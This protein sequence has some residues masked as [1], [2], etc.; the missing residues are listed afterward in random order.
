M[1]VYTVKWNKKTALTV[2]IAAAVIICA[3]IFIIGAGGNDGPSCTVRNNEDRVEFL[4]SLGWEVDAEAVSERTII[5]PQEFSEIYSAYNELQIAQGYDLSQYCGLEATVYTYPITN[6]SGY[7]G[8][9]VLDLY[10]LNY[11][12][13]GGDV[14]SLELDGFMH[15]LTMK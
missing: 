10:V 11:E 13:V 5:I 9:V 14:H 7:S 4:L 6:Y 3:L 1:F 15:G 2:V 12:V 8:R